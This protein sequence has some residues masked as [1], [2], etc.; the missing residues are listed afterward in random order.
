MSG[1]RNRKQPLSPEL[2]KLPRVDDRPPTKGNSSGITR[3]ISDL[4]SGLKIKSNG[5]LAL[6][7]STLIRSDHQEVV[8]DI[9]RKIYR[10]LSDIS[11]SRFKLTLPNSSIGYLFQ[12]I[13]N[14]WVP[15]LELEYEILRKLVEAGAGKRK[16]K[17]PLHVKRVLTEEH[18]ATM[19]R[20]GVAARKRWL[21]EKQ[22]IRDSLMVRMPDVSP[23]DYFEG[24]SAETESGSGSPP[25]NDSP[26]PEVA[27]AA[28]TALPEPLP[29]PWEV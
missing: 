13:M 11:Y 21:Q 3:Y 5:D 22:E 29:H 25:S 12:E 27:Q 1:T 4:K 18:V 20:E 6:D 23:C 17:Q 2:Q 9:Q 16:K 8:F 7:W 24:V 28:A 10:L 26:A 14:S 19:N 15:T